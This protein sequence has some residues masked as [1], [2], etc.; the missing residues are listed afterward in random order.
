MATVRNEEHKICKRTF[1]YSPNNQS[2]A[3]CAPRHGIFYLSL[4]PSASMSTSMLRDPVA[5]RHICICSCRHAKRQP[6]ERPAQRAS[7]GK[8]SAACSVEAVSTTHLGRIEFDRSMAST[9]STPFFELRT[10][11]A[12]RKRPEDVMIEFKNH[13]Q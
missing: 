10:S 6:C 9:L 13:C 3:S 5:R 7:R 1:S 12:G 8:S 4:N 2:A 11:T